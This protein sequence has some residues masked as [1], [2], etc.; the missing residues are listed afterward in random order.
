MGPPNGLYNGV[1]GCIQPPMS[2][3]LPF[4]RRKALSEMTRDEWE[5]LCDGCGKCCLIKLEDEDSGDIIATDVTCK[6]MDLGTCQCSRYP[7]RSV[8]VPDCVT[9]TPDNIGTLNFM[10]ATCAYRLLAEGQP[11]A[12]WHP[13][14]SGDPNSV[15]DAGMSVLDRVVPETEVEDA[16][17]ED[18]VIDWFD[19]KPGETPA[20]PG[21]GDDASEEYVIELFDAGVTEA[22][23]E[24]GDPDAGY[25][26]AGAVDRNGDAA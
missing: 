15:H 24:D 18:R 3:K 17:L 8:H 10:P 22:D 16:D 26:E 7:E 2:S 11:L 25:R 14:V 12:D 9:L 20:F 5:S 21:W 13:L 6:L 19:G 1:S 4:W 23:P